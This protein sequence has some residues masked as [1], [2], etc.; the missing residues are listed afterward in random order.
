M[1]ISGQNEIVIAR[2]YNITAG[3]RLVSAIF[4]VFCLSGYKRQLA[5]CFSRRRL[6]EVKADS[7]CNL[8]FVGIVNGSERNGVLVIPEMRVVEYFVSRNKVRF[9]GGVFKSIVPNG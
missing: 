4:V 6:N 5:G 7:V 3:I 1:E 8:H 9:A 2:P